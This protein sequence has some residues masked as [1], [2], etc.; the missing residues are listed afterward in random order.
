MKKKIVAILLGT[1]VLMSLTG[2]GGGSGKGT[3]TTEQ[4]T[5]TEDTQASTEAVPT[6]KSGEFEIKLDSVVSKLSDYKGISLELSS[7]Y[8]VTDEACNEYLTILLTNTGA[9]A[10]REVKDHDTV[11]ADDIVNVDYTGYKDGEA[12]DGGAAK[13]QY[14]DVGGNKAAG[15][16]MG[17]IEGFTDGL[18]GAK[19][20]E[21][22][23][24]PCTFPENY[25]SEDLAGQDVE[26]EF[27]VN[28]IYEPIT[29]D[30]LTDEEVKKNF[31]ETAKLTT[32]KDLKKAIN[33]ILEQ[34][35]YSAK[36]EAA[37]NYLVE[38][39]TIEIPEDY[40]NARLYEYM[41]TFEADNCSDTESLEDYLTKNYNMTLDAAKSS[42]KENLE[43]QIKIEF[44]FELIAEK[45]KIEVDEEAYQ[46][47]VDYIVS[48]ESYSFK[49]EEEAYKYFGAGNVEHGKTYIRNQYLVNKA[50]DIVV[51]EA[52]VTFQ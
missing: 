19:V 23:K 4:V 15:S 30:M 46:S 32:V 8:K 31:E 49:D 47:F 50:I 18:V 34:N 45:E 20:G 7:K 37:K 52:E 39:S 40:L 9:D 35:L 33:A 36:V 51:D 25:Q 1:S 3:E 48:S 22:V 6:K 38:N 10:Y 21:T 27:K 26:F 5:V 43:N 29:F 28:G 17:Y 13:D 12:F 2:C 44:L 16:S 14:I 41:D 42:W 11:A 24:S